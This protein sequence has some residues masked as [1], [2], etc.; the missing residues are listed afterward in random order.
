[1]VVILLEIDAGCSSCQVRLQGKGKAPFHV[2]V[3]IKE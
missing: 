3:K 1:M 2:M